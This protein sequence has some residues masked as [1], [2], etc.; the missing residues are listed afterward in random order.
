MRNGLIA[1]SSA[2][3]L[4]G[5]S[6]IN[7]PSQA[8]PYLWCAVH[9]MSG[10]KQDCYFKSLEQCRAGTVDGGGCVPNMAYDRKDAKL[11]RRHH[12]LRY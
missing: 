10:E 6:A 4:L 9:G 7:S 3:A 1:V 8:S 2:L 12:A 11:G 5:L